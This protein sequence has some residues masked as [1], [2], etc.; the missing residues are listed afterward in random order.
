M[1]TPNVSS[2]ASVTIVYRKDKINAKN[3][4]PIH[5][6]IIKNRKA[7]YIASGIMIPPNQW[8]D[9][10]NKV[11][12]TY[13]N[14]ARL[15]SYLSNKFTE[16]QDTVLQHET[17]SKSFTSQNLKE[18]V[19]GKKPQDFFSFAENIVAQYKKE[20]RIGTYDKNRSVVEKLKEYKFSLTF[21]DI[22]PEFLMKYEQYLREVHGNVTNTVGKDMKFIRKVFNDAI[23]SDII[24]YETNP[25][26][27]YKIKQERTHRDYLTE[28][29]LTRIEGC[30]VNPGSRLE[31][32]KNMFVFACYTGGLRVSDMLQ[33]KWANFDGIYLNIVITKTGAQLSIKIPN[34]GLQIIS[35]YRKEDTT[36]DD[37]IFPMLRPT[38]N[39]NDPVALDAAITSA[40][41]LINKNLKILAKKSEI[42]KR[43][44]FHI[45]RHSFAVMALRKGITIDKVS[46]LM[47][48]S[49]I[50]ETQVY[51]KIV[52]EELD[53]AMDIFNQ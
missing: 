37:F 33:L 12:S 19:F 38:L 34:K 31:L 18:K 23:K 44:S 49:A 52:S 6:R 17:L 21:Y 26:R 11:K 4:A 46:K 13:R 9:K 51:A 15:N 42:Q 45:S 14:S 39:M 53:K 5:F 10:K 1:F 35:K 41:T 16:I 47:A 50:K 8:D 25:F 20:G 27:K 28:E 36:R 30:N 2:M 22:T 29:E 32:S 40:T 3:E 7:S 48:H 43:L 24:G